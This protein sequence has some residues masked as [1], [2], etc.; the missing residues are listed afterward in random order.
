MSWHNPTIFSD[1]FWRGVVPERWVISLHSLQKDNHVKL[2]TREIQQQLL[3][4]FS[5][6]PSLFDWFSRV[7][8]ISPFFK[9]LALTN[10]TEGIY[11]ASTNTPKNLSKKSTCPSLVVLKHSP[12]RA[13]SSSK[14]SAKP[15]RTSFNLQRTPHSSC[16][17]KTTNPKWHV[18]N[19]DTYAQ[20]F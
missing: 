12:D 7:S 4:D 18:K 6:K 20:D 16:S 19:L 17:L 14:T 13:I 3:K 1:K 15:G 2:A 10:S 8:K 11:S 9:V 5:I